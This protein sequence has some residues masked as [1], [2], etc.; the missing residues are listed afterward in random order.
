MTL[1][2][3]DTILKVYGGLPHAF[4]VHPDLPQ[5]ARYFQSMVDWIDQLLGKTSSDGSAAQGL[6]WL[7]VV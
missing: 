1:V 6:D 4:Y 7:K 5:S 2:R 3:V